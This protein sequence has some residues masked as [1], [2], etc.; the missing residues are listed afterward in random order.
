MTNVDSGK[1]ISCSDLSKQGF[2]LS[3]SIVA[4]AAT[5]GAK[6]Q[7]GK[8]TPCVVGEIPNLKEFADGPDIIG[9][10][11][12]IKPQGQSDAYVPLELLPFLPV[13]QMALDVDVLTLGAERAQKRWVL[14]RASRHTSDGSGKAHQRHVEGWHT[15]ATLGP[16]LFYLASD[17]FGT[18]LSDN[19][20][21]PDGSIIVIDQ[22]VL[23]RS[24]VIGTQRRTFFVIAS[25]A[26]DPASSSTRELHHN[27]MIH[28]LSE[29]K[30]P[31]R[32][33]KI[34]H[35]R[36]AGAEVLRTQYDPHRRKQDLKSWLRGEM[37]PL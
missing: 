23:H 7:K 4:M 11:L 5:E 2:V 28:S 6:Q 33:A 29:L 16:C 13:I 3:S 31:A 32:N 35:W 20:K 36:T 8:F 25:Y 24:P 22:S 27:P 30:G 37:T 21:A 1:T 19:N 26:S 10:G 15:H 14:V 12:I 17:R 9:N 34:A 18:E